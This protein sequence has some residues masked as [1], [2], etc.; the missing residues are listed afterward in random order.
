MLHL[1][2]HRKPDR[3][4]A[5]GQQQAP[6]PFPHARQHEDLQLADSF[7]NSATAPLLQA[8][9]IPDSALADIQPIPG[10]ER[11]H[12][13]GASKVDAETHSDGR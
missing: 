6:S 3:A 2:H 7:K 5:K 1:V 9:L 4:Y 12:A 11:C 10:P 8:Q 13:A